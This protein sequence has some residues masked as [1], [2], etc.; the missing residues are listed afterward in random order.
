MVL[1]IKERKFVLLYKTIESAAFLKI[2]VYPGYQMFELNLLMV[3]FVNIS[4]STKLLQHYT[5][6]NKIIIFNNN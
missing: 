1:F 4:N 3:L 5:T 6:K 2:F